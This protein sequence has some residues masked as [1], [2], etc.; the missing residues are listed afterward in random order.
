MHVGVNK[1]QGML[2]NAGTRQGLR[3]Y[4]ESN[5]RQFPNLKISLIVWTDEV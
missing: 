5:I 2:N 4:K 1:T 3:S